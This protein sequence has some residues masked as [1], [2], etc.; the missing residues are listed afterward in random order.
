MPR[1]R[2]LNDKLARLRTLRKNA[3]ALESVRELR[4]A[5]AD[6]S[7]LVVAEAAEI[8]GAGRV[9]ELAPEL[10]SAFDYFLVKPLQRD[11]MCRAKTALAE[12]LNNLEY[13]GEDVFWRGARHVQP[14]PVWGGTQDTAAGL[15]VTCAFALVRNRARGVMAFLVALPA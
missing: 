14:E 6:K 13:P 8:I 12:A 5:L 11:K 15:R 4:A 1:G 2:S 10:V 9:A 7:N 3:G